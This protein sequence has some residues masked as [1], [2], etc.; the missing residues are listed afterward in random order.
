MRPNR[1]ANGRIMLG[2]ALLLMLLP[3]SLAFGWTYYRW[4][5]EKGIVHFT[6]TF[7]NIPRAYRDRAEVIESK[8]KPI[9]SL[10]LP[11]TPS[12]EGDAL[13]EEQ[14]PPG[15]ASSGLS[16]TVGPP[17]EVQ[18][19]ATPQEKASPKVLLLQKQVER[20]R[21]MLEEATDGEV[22]KAIQKRIEQKEQELEMQRA[23]DAQS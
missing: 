16:D 17:Q 15:E 12:P 11:A 22:R 7:T 4:E 19:P 2:C 6:N 10:R 23:L 8:R 21:D 5:D 20:D 3:P 18:E 13:S 14:G 9:T 1:R